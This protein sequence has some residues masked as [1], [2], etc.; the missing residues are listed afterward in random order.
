MTS[1]PQILV[2][3]TDGIR[4]LIADNPARLN[5]YTRTMWESLPRLLRDA[6]QDPT[7]R[8][9]VLTGV[10]DKAFSAGA[11]ISEF[12]TERTGEQARRY[13]DFNNTAFGALV[14]CPKPVIAM[15]NGLAF[16]GGCELAACCDFRIAASHATFS[17]PAARLG[18]GYNARWIKP[19]LALISPA[20]AKEMLMTA[21]RYDAASALSMGLVNEVVPPSDLRSRTLSLAAEL[22][23]NAPLSLRAAKLCVDALAHPDG[24]VDMAKLDAAVHD[25]FASTDYTEGRTAFM[26]KRKPRFEGR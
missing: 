13:D 4:W 25:C 18:I 15:V 14:A 24:A 16:G 7:V 9:I 17:I 1:L 3:T 20:K 12:G 8:V 10:G 22:A 26:Q 19:L 5:A 21:R 2:E 23:E 11:D 6:A